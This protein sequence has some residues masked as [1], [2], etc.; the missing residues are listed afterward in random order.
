MIRAVIF[1]LDGVLVTTDE[2]HYR[3]WKQLA[4]EEGIPFDRSRNDRLRGVSRMESLEIVLELAA[5]PYSP[6]EKLEMA[7]RKNGYYRGFL[8]SLTPDDV[9]PGAREMLVE[10]RSRGI[11]IAIGSSS[12]NA[13]MIMERVGLTDLVDAI[14]D[15]NHIKAS[16]PD[17][18]VFLLAAEAL[19]VEPSECVVVEDAAAGVEAARRAGMAVFGIGTPESPIG[20]SNMA[21][22]LAEV[23]ADALLQAE[24]LRL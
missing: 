5:K 21:R 8:A 17:P 9:L 12:K 10:L 18:E 19:G 16:K 6:D 11:L 2:M 24:G 1:D 23:A 15:G 13:P 3:G 14:V 4:D 22:S 20:A 7:T